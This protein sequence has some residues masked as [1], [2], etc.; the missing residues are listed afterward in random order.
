MDRRAREDGAAENQ[1]RVVCQVRRESVHHL[2]EERH[3]WV[4]ELI[5]GR[6]DDDD[7]DGYARN[8]VR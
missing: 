6:A 5:D 2:I 3:G 4:H 8:E 1:E 7:H